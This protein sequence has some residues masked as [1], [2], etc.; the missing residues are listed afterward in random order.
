MI[1]NRILT[2]LTLCKDMN[3]R[4]AAEELNMTQPAVTQHIQYLE[5]EYGCKLFSYDKRVL[6]IT[7]EGKE[8]KKHAENIVYQDNK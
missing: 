3:Y 4:K 6:T 2:F 1:D 8:L 5:K 7:N